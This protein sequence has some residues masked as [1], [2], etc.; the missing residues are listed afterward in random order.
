MIIFQVLI[1][2]LFSAV[3]P[4]QASLQGEHLPKT[5]LSPLSALKTMKSAQYCHL[6]C[7][8]N[9]KPNIWEETCTAVCCRPH[10]RRGGR[11]LLQT[12]LVP[13]TPP[14][15]TGLFCILF[16]FP[17]FLSVFRRS[18]AV[19]KK[20]NPDKVSVVSKV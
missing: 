13:S 4:S 14:G 7:G 15:G 12:C 6:H 5:L 16:C 20:K 18:Q 8:S 11:A 17:C 1:V 9:I 10:S 19:K 3:E 2:C